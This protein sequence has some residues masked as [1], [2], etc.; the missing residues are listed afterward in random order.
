MPV[1]EAAVFETREPEL[2][3]IRRNPGFRNAVEP[4]NRTMRIRADAAGGFNDSACA[5]HHPVAFLH[6]F[7]A[8]TQNLPEGDLRWAGVH[9]TFW[10]LRS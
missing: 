1:I 4:L 5:L 3:P 7:A 10:A 9:Y 6:G 2:I 8:L